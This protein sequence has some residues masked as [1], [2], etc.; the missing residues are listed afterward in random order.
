MDACVD[1]VTCYLLDYWIHNTVHSS[2]VQVKLN[3]KEHIQN[4]TKI[5]MNSNETHT[6]T[7]NTN[8]VKVD[9]SDIDI[10]ALKEYVNDFS[11]SRYFFVSY[12]NMLEYDQDSIEKA[13]ILSYINPSPGNVNRW[14]QKHY[15]DFRLLG[16]KCF[17]YVIGILLKLPRVAHY[18]S[19]YI[20]MVVL[21][22]IALSVSNNVFSS[23]PYVL[24]LCI[25]IMLM[26]NLVSICASSSD[27]TSVR[28]SSAD[29]EDDANGDR[30]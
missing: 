25:F 1:L 8:Q 24:L 13:Y 30:F 15:E 23:A 9:A 27:F 21:L 16:Q 6:K 12:K 28:P 4:V 20:T 14:T 19:I 11:A 22:A 29:T 5:M 10:N 7:H 3:L 17:I 18:M 26:I 2:V